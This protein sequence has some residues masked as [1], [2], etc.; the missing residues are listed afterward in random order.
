[1]FG[2]Q[3]IKVQQTEYIL[4]YKKGQLAREGAGLAFFYFAPTTSLVKVPC[5]SV[6]QPFIFEEVTSDF[7]DITIQGQV[8]Y[9]VAEPQKLSGLMDYSLTADGKGF[10][11]EDPQKLSQR[12]IN[13]TQV[14]T[15]SSLKNMPLRETLG[16]SDSLVKLLLKNLQESE[17]INQLGV[18]VLS[19]S[20]LA[21]K[22]T[23][24]TLR[25]LEAEAREAILLEADEAIYSRR[26]AAIEQERAI[27]ENELNTEIAVENKKKQVMEARMEAEKS[28]QEKKRELREAE[29][30][31][32]I[33]LEQQKGDLV[34]LSTENLRQEADA[35]A[36]G[37]SVM[38]KA[39]A[40]TDPKTLQVLANRDMDA[41]Q[42]VAMAFKELAEG[43]DKIGQLNVSPDLLRELIETNAR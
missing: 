19:M 40:E 16:S 25:A 28:A 27:K 14:L 22:P 41:S 35:K 21:I 37:I 23:R 11:S 3:F 24:E 29:M 5:G 42:L 33:A 31:T 13:Y 20:I 34:D 30:N 43:A 6:D 32:Q 10:T 4:Q 7:Q 12:L 26:N 36:Y 15:R 18:E 8:T 17:T 39:L 1:M 38:M 9:R 2:I